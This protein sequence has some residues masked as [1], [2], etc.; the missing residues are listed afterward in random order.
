MPRP[1]PRD[2]DFNAGKAVTADE[3][4]QAADLVAADIEP[5]S[6]LR[7]SDDYRREMVRVI[8]R[9]TIGQ[10]FGLATD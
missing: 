2:A 4:A 9:R 10:L 7:G 5:I 8:A 1:L 6:D 3:A